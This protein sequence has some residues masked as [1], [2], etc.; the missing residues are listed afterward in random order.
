MVAFTFFPRDGDVVSPCSSIL[1]VVGR[2]ARGGNDS[3]LSRLAD[4]CSVSIRFMLTPSSLICLRLCCSQLQNHLA[5]WKRRRT[6]AT[7]LFPDTESTRT[8]AILSVQS[9][10]LSMRSMSARWTILV[11]RLHSRTWRRQNSSTVKALMRIHPSM[12]LLL[13]TETRLPLVPLVILIDLLRWSIWLVCIMRDSRSGGTDTTQHR[14]R[15][16]Y[17]RQ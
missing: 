13:C 3:H 15:Y 6:K 1:L 4:P 2:Q 7:T 11:G 9:L 17:T 12:S 5:V 14:Q 16:C 8:N 10:I